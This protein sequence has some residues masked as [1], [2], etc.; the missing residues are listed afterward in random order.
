MEKH[1][2]T[3]NWWPKIKNA[4]VGVGAGIRVELMANF[5]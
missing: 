3:Y 5:C 2:G 4:G 1:K